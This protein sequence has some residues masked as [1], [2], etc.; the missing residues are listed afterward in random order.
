M[1]AN[2]PYW[3]RFSERRIRYSIICTSHLVILSYWISISGNNKRSSIFSGNIS[4]Y[5]NSKYSNKCNLLSSN[6]TRCDFM[7]LSNNWFIWDNKPSH[8]VR[9]GT[10]LSNYKMYPRAALWLMGAWL[11]KDLRFDAGNRSE[12]K[13]IGCWLPGPIGSCCDELLRNNQLLLEPWHFEIWQLN[14]AR[15]QYLC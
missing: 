1:Y 8:R 3:I 14:P 10:L 2:K 5:N 11:R 12:T 13:L 9:W 4:C 6:Y 15:K 7:V